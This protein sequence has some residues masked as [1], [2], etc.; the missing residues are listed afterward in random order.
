MVPAEV[1]GDFVFEIS[2][3]SKKPALRIPDDSG[4]RR[5]KKIKNPPDGSVA[6]LMNEKEAS[7]IS[8]IQIA[9]IFF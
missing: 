6:F 4:R 9:E 2:G 1:P 8:A 3:E 7:G 5:G